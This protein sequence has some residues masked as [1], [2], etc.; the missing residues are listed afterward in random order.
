MKALTRTASDTRRRARVFA[1][2]ALSAAMVLMMVVPSFGATTVNLHTPHVGAS[3][4][5]FNNESDDGGLSADVVW[6]FVLNGL[7]RGTAAA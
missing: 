2:V 5:T 6:H 1:T 7:D 4:S 3:S